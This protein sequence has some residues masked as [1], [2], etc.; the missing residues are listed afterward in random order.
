METTSTIIEEETTEEGNED[1]RQYNSLISCSNGYHNK[2]RV[3]KMDLSFPHFAKKQCATCY[4]FI[5]WV[6]C[7]EWDKLAYH[8]KLDDNGDIILGI[9]VYRQKL[10]DDYFDKL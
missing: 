4:K 10:M 9:T 1:E 8:N 2:C 7:I 3:K 5:S 6:N